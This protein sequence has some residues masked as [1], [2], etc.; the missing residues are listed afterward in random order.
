MLSYTTKTLGKTG[1]VRLRGVLVDLE[2]VFKK[3]RM[4]K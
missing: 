1:D 2:G 4:T 3:L